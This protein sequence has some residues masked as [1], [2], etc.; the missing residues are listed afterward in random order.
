MLSH[1][2]AFSHHEILIFLIV[3]SCLYHSLNT[4]VYETMQ[5]FFSFPLSLFPLISNSLLDLMTFLCSI[6]NLEDKKFPIS[7][8]LLDNIVT[9]FCF[10]FHTL[11]FWVE[12]GNWMEKSNESVNL[13]FPISFASFIPSLIPALCRSF[14][15]PDLV[16]LYSH[17][18][19]HHFLGREQR[20][21]GI[22]VVRFRTILSFREKKEMRTERERDKRGASL[23]VWEPRNW[24]SLS[25]ENEMKRSSF[26]FSLLVLSCRSQ[27]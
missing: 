22:V 8:E 9:S 27:A 24:L 1:V 18:N 20:G 25:P 7:I 26:L 17:F 23:L 3:K 10:V 21:S 19:L 14:I 15:D 16:S 2:F 11:S 12:N 4:N 13:T 5:F 6:L